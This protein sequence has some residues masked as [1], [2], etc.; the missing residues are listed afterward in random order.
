MRPPRR[1][2][3][4]RPRLA[5]LLI[6][7]ASEHVRDFRDGAALSSAPSVETAGEADLISTPDGKLESRLEGAVERL[8]AERDGALIERVLEEAR[9]GDRGTAGAQET[10]AALEEGRV[11]HL[12]LD[13]ARAAA[14]CSSPVLEAEEAVAG[15]GVGSEALARGALAGAA[16][17]SIV[18]GSAAEL[19][20]PVG[21]VAA[22]LRY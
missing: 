17:I 19:L 15:D 9:G 12:V 22:L 18:S 6:F 13:A 8:V 21:G 10:L 20:A 1:P 11:D 7:G 5:Q 2:R 3:G 14:A 16:R 4:L